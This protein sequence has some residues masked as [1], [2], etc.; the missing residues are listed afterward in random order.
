MTPV[1]GVEPAKEGSQQISGR[2]RYPLNHR[3]TPV[4]ADLPLVF[5][6]PDDG[7]TVASESAL[8]SAGT[9][10]SQVRARAPAS[11]PDRGLKA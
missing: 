2:I 8:K 4:S 10:L 1:A 11:W 9:L 5:Y 6:S 3:R 7:G